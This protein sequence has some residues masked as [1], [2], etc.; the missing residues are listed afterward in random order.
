MDKKTLIAELVTI[1]AWPGATVVIVFLLRVPIRNLLDG[2]KLRKFKHKNWEAEFEETTREI[3]SELQ[4]TTKDLRRTGESLIEELEYL[5]TSSPTETILT[6]WNRIEQTVSLLAK[7]YGIQEYTFLT[8]LNRLVQKNV[9]GLSTKDSLLGL[10]QLRNLAVHGINGDVSEARAREF[11]TMADAILWVISSK[12][13]KSPK[14]TA[15]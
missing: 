4:V 8:I 7:K 6:A 12:I 14:E 2:I 5:I 10:R 9:V 1:L 11:L 3:R 13:E 15:S